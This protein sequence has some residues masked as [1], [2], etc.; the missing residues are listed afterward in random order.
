M[1]TVKDAEKLAREAHAGQFRND[2]ITPYIVHPEAVA[3]SMGSD[4]EQIIAWLHDVVEDTHIEMKD[5]MLLN[6][7]FEIMRPINSLTRKD[8]ESYLDYILRVKEDKVAIRV[9]L[10]DMKHNSSTALKTHKEKY[11]IAAYILTN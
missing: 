5:L 6:I 7:P 8:D 3:N 9:K 2:G 1:F 4:D 11:E 10:A